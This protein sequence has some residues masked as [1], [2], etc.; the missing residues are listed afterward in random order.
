M[1][2]ETKGGLSSSTIRNAIAGLFVWIGGKYG[3][4]VDEVTV[5]SIIQDFLGVAA[6]VGVIY[7]RV[8]AATKIDRVI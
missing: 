2:D 6:T 7:G 5:A 1:F 4:I 8:K 3:F